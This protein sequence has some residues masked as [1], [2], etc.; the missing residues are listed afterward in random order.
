[1]VKSGLGSEVGCLIF[2]SYRVPLTLAKFHK[3][4]YF[5]F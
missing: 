3:T 1:M 2:I 4:N 5:W